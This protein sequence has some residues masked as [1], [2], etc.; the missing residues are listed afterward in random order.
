MAPGAW[1]LAL[2]AW[3]LA[4]APRI[5]QTLHVAAT[6]FFDGGCGLCHRAVLFLLRRDR[7]GS[8][9]LFAPIGG[10]SFRRTVAP[11]DREHLPDSVVLRT[12]EGRL[13]VRSEAL[14]VALTRLG[15]GWRAA[16][17]VARLLPRPLR[18]AVYDAVARAR[19]RLFA[20]PRGSC[21]TVPEPLRR[22]FLE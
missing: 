16:A 10:E 8:R 11:P 12:E 3:R 5:G 1:R 9:F 17:A 7:D 20:P 18:D 14:L 19:K 2:G 6:L 4:P 21:P 15:G 22:R 13:L